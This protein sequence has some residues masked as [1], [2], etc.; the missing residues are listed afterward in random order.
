MVRLIKIN[1][2]EDSG[3]FTNQFQ[4]IIN[5]EADSQVALVN[6]TFSIGLNNIIL[7]SSNNTLQYK[8]INTELMIP[9][10][11][12]IGSYTQTALVE[13]MRQKINAS[14]TIMY[15]GITPL[16]FDINPAVNADGKFTLSFEKTDFIESDATNCTLYNMALA[17]NVWTAGSASGAIFSYNKWVSTK[18]KLNNGSGLAQCTPSDNGIFGLMVDPPAT[19]S[20]LTPTDF[21]IALAYDTG[22]NTYWKVINGERTT[23]STVPAFTQLF[24]KLES[25]SVSF[26]EGA[27]ELFSEA[28]DYNTTGY[29]VVSALQK[30]NAT[31]SD[32]SFNEQSFKI[33]NSTEGYTIHSPDN[34]L[35]IIQLGALAPRVFDMRFPK[36][37]ATLLGF[38]VSILR[39][40]AISK[41]FTA[42]VKLVD[43]ILDESIEVHLINVGDIKSYDS[44]SKKTQRIIAVIP[45][46][47]IVVGNR[48]AYSAPELMYIDLN[49]KFAVPISSLTFRIVGAESGEEIIFESGVVMTLAVRSKK[50]NYM[51]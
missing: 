44:V 22:T 14:Q 27:T 46:G 20:T 31:V 4:E 29:F 7:G 48:L 51:V 36:K 8:R 18:A 33:T 43:S 2:E 21:G 34:M 45:L 15:D 39:V 23:L 12:D 5:F 10:T 13:E 24:I 50:E 17:G 42:S 49:N 6:S 32:F 26:Y 37:L 47:S 19:A 16:G 40:Q 3:F 30:L 11:L 38:S 41:T 9:V 28:Y 25:G 1:N 35:E